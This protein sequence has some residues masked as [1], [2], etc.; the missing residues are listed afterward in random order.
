MRRLYAKKLGVHPVSHCQ[1]KRRIRIRHW[2][3]DLPRIGEPPHILLF[4]PS[5][6]SPFL[7]QHPSFSLFL[8]F[9]RVFSN[10][11]SSAL[12]TLVLSTRYPSRYWHWRCEVDSSEGAERSAEM[13]TRRGGWC[14]KK[15]K[16]TLLDLASLYSLYTSVSV[17]LSVSWSPLFVHPVSRFPMGNASSDADVSNITCALHFSSVSRVLLICPLHFP[18]YNNVAKSVQDYFYRRYICWHYSSKVLLKI[19]LSV[20]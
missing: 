2:T 10:P 13:V 3:R 5:R 19:M 14:E 17:C 20:F 16:K 11:L 15:K 6:S 7:F 12:A 9:L 8:V 1:C 18:V 4:L